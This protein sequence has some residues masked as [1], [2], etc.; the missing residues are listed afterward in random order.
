MG[1]Q[2]TIARHNEDGTFD[3][4]YLHYDGYT[5]HAFN[6]LRQHYNTQ[7]LV[8]A[9]IELGDLSSLNER[10]APDAGEDHTFMSP[11]RGV[12][13]AYHRDRGEDRARTKAQRVPILTKSECAAYTYVWSNGAWYGFYCAKPI[14]DEETGV[15][16]LA[17]M[18]HEIEHKV[19]DDD[20]DDADPMDDYNYVGSPHHY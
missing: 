16:P 17:T 7:E 5:E 3:T 1:T 9:L 10:I 12:T 4:I 8:D 11:V 20:A 2:A 13:I 19:N 6:I 18:L 15:L 14:V